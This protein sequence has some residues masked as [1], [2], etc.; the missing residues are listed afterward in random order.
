MTV[1]IATQTDRQEIWRLLLQS[2]N[3]NGLF[4]L[5]PRKVDF[6]LDRVLNP[7]LIHPEDPGPRGE[8]A[9]I[10][11]PGALEALAFI[12]IGSF[13]YSEDF[14][15]EELIVYVSPEYRKEGHA[16]NLIEWM[17]ATADT[18]GIKLITGV[19]SNHRTEAKVRLYERQL[20]KIGAF[21]MYPN[22][23]RTLQ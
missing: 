18:L 7:Q 4:T 2:H 19:M 5:S 9:I 8:I 11:E 3:E 12:L 6:L 16:K 10:G 14:H 20:P 23:P 1:R 22:G 21:F 13:W 17:K 15:L